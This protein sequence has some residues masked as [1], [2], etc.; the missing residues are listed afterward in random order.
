M[1]SLGSCAIVEKKGTVKERRGRFNDAPSIHE[2]PT[3]DEDRNQFGHWEGD[4]VRGKTGCS[5]LATI[6]DRKSRFLL[7]QG[8]PKAASQFV[9]QAILNFFAEA[10]PKRVRSFTPARGSEFSKY[11]E[12]MKELEIP[13]FFLDPH[14][15]QQQG[16]NS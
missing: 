14:A 10:T 15:R 16:T 3:S 4:T 6:V 13:V 1:G 11:H 2:R 9:F 5:A 7:S 8:A 12:L